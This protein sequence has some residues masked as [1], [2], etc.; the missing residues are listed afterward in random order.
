MPN[1]QV[2]FKVFQLGQLS[3]S[4]ADCALGLANLTQ[5]AYRFELDPKIFPCEE[6]RYRLK[7]GA[8]DLDGAVKTLL[9]RARVA[10]PVI[11]LTSLA[12]GD[13]STEDDPDDGYFSSEALEFD[14]EASIVSTHE[15]TKL[16]GERPLQPYILLSLAM[17]ALSRCARLQFHRETHG[18]VFDYCYNTAHIDRVFSSEGLCRECQR[19]VYTAVQARRATME[20]VTSSRKLLNRAVGR[21]T[22]FVAMPFRKALDPVYETLRKS[23]KPL[24]WTVTRADEAAQARWI[25]DAI[26]EGIMSSDLVIADATGDNPNV[27]YELGFA[28]AIGCDTVII[29]QRSREKASA[30]KPIAPFD[31]SVHRIISYSTTANGLKQL[32]SDI[33][34]QAGDARG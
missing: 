28:H 23:L 3:R 32:A 2:Q 22:C 18:C 4:E 25:T 6:K 12:Y 20:Q 33:A 8:Y 9:R 1:E 17:I 19:R 5:Q 34:V 27:F 26:V 7:N 29:K 16:P 21:K 15:W 31:I 11:F 24:G 30:G 14:P 13:R 10:R